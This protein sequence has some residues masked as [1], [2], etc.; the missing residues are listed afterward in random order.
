MGALQG[1]TEAVK[2]YKEEFT[3]LGAVYREFNQL[4]AKMAETAPIAFATV[5]ASAEQLVSV[6]QQMQTTFIGVANA[7]GTTLAS[8]FD[9]Y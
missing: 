4:M 5:T 2:K 8:S 6:G 9:G 1:Q 7:I 3:M